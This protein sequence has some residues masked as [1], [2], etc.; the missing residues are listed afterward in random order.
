MSWIDLMVALLGMPALAASLYLMIL[1][2]LAKPDRQPPPSERCLKFDIVVPAHNEEAD[3]VH[4]I[5][6]L[7]LVAYPRELFRIVVVA[8]NC[9]D[10]TAALAA[11]A[12][13]HVLVR[14]DSQHRG[15]GYALAFAFDQSRAD[16]FADAIVVVD[17]DTVVSPN[18][19][20]CF[21]SR[22][23]AGATAL[24]A[25]YGVRNPTA[26]WRTR[27]LTIALAA[28]H[29]VR[30][31]SRQ[32]LR[33]SC[34]LRGNG[35][36][37]SSAL[38]RNHPYRAFSIVEDVEY[39]LELGY[40]GVR[41]HYVPEATVHG[42]MAVSERASRSQRRRW[43][44]GRYALIR[45]HV[46]RLLRT[47]WQHRD[48]IPL[49]LAID[50]L[51][52]PLSQLV[53]LNVMGTAACLGVAWTIGGLYLAPVVWGVSVAGVLLYVGRGWL[54]SGVGLR[55]LCDL[56]WA[57]SYIFWKLAMRF[58]ADGRRRADSAWIRTSREAER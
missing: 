40:A 33:L 8:D 32:R 19:L 27:L 5:A 15:K 36:A 26:S 31:L 24:Q 7:L 47:A 43:E 9:T 42:T 37:F 56:L 20:S 46:A 49:D 57:P 1:A 34:G 55:G 38:L 28:F 13:A 44:Q 54:L 16:G 4:T 10:R 25:E 23:E 50:L 17:A 12:G 58:T 48:P 6:S 2:L 53:I 11:Q 51:V 29:G 18:L 30:S 22:L 35:M 3:I 14:N 21:A 41:V 52:P 45:R 39:G